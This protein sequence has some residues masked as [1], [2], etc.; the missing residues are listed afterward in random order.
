MK[1]IRK[2]KEPASLLEHRADQHSYENLNKLDTRMALLM[3]Q[4]YICCYCMKRIPEKDIN[5]GCKIEHFNCQDN[6]KDQE[7]DYNNMLIACYGNEGSPEM[8][9]TCDTFKQNKSLS[10][11][12]ASRQRN[13][14]ELI[15]YKP[16]GE[17][18]STDEQLNEIQKKAFLT[19]SKTFFSIT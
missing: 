4:G 3:E 17:I 6:H 7:L 13:I 14:E 1:Q 5:P 2:N 15:K 12:P 19:H 16:N 9:Q 18:Y 10:I 8:I 11:S